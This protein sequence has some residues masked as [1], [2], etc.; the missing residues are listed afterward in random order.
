MK[1]I[2]LQRNLPLCWLGHLRVVVLMVICLHHPSMLTPISYKSSINTKDRTLL[3]NLHLLKKCEHRWVLYNQRNKPLE[4]EY[5]HSGLRVRF[6]EVQSVTRRKMCRIK[7]SLDVGQV[8]KLFGF[9]F[10]QSCRSDHAFNRVGSAVPKH[11]L[12]RR[13]CLV[14][15]NMSRIGHKSYTLFILYYTNG[16]SAGILTG[17]VDMLT[18]FHYIDWGLVKTLTWQ[19]AN[20]LT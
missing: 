4:G 14:Y 16:M 10:W 15:P 3:K 2:C 5:L 19:S 6:L 17:M 8:I 13:V 9:T 18:I 1:V 20:M 11:Y 7:Y 12:P